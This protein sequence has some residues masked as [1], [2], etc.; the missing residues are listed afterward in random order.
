VRSDT[1]NPSRGITNS[2]LYS[3]PCQVDDH[4]LTSVRS[5]HLETPSC[6]RRGQRRRTCSARRPIRLGAGGKSL[7]SKPVVERKGGD[8]TRLHVML[9]GVP[10]NALPEF[11]RIGS[12]IV[13]LPPLRP[14][15]VN[16]LKRPWMRG[17]TPISLFR[18]HRLQLI[19]NPPQS[20]GL[21]T[22]I[23][24]DSPP[25]VDISISLYHDSYHDSGMCRSVARRKELRRATPSSLASSRAMTA[26]H[27]GRPRPR[28]PWEGAPGLD[29]VRT[30]SASWRDGDQRE[31]K[32]LEGFG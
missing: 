15:T 11:E 29:P 21:R 26:I 30:F 20:S 24:H 32:R 27:P 16:K 9:N 2:A 28:P 7:G 18:K 23:G 17:Q 13:Q 19:S 31:P 12:P 8:V 5:P 6:T 4:A 3:V 1:L 22:H 14:S 10:L 25:L